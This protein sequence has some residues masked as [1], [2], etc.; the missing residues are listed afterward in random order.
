MRGF[1]FDHE[2]VRRETFVSNNKWNL[3]AQTA[4][5]LKVRKRERERTRKKE[6]GKGRKRK[7]EQAHGFN[8]IAASMAALLGRSNEFLSLF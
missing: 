1:G 2:R 6:G 3:S 7:R 8:S 4:K 5:G